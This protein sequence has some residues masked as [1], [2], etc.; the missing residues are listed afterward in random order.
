MNISV[1]GEGV[2][3]NEASALQRRKRRRLDRAARLGVASMR[4]PLFSGGNVEKHGP[5]TTSEIMLQ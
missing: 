1:V 3:F 4:P 2:S 5:V